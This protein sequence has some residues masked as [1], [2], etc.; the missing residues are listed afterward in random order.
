MGDAISVEFGYIAEFE[1]VFAMALDKSWG[2]VYSFSEKPAAFNRQ[3][4]Y[5]LIRLFCFYLNLFIYSYGAKFYNLPHYEL[6]VFI[7]GWIY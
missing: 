7:K 4:R 3:A 1:S 6:T 5:L 2:Q